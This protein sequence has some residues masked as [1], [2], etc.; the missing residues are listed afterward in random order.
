MKALKGMRVHAEISLSAGRETLASQRGEIQFTEFG[1]S[2]I[3]AMQLSRF[4]SLKKG[5]RM[6]RCSICCQLFRTARRRI[7]S[8]A[9]F[10]TTLEL[11]GASAHRASPEE[12]RAGFV[13]AGGD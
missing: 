13:E 2:G 4:V 8:Q 6:E 7:T 3:A 1:L 5:R 10:G 11:G 9:A 12:G